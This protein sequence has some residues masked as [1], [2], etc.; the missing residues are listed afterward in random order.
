MLYWLRRTWMPRLAGSNTAVSPAAAKRFWMSPVVVPFSRSP[1]VAG[2]FT[3][4][5]GAVAV[6]VLTVVSVWPRKVSGGRDPGER[7]RV[8]EG[9]SR[10]ARYWA[11]MGKPSALRAP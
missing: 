2:K 9:T 8:A 7:V 1:T 4:E 3:F 5:I 6:N 11:L 10:F